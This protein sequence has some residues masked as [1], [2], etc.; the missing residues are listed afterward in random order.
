MEFDVENLEVRQLTLADLSAFILLIHLFNTVFEADQSA[1][2]S[3]ANLLELLSNNHFVAIAAF[4]ENELVGGLTGYELPMY[5]SE[6][7]EIF[8]YD[9]AVKLEYQRRGI[10]IRLIDSLKEYCTK[11]G[12]ND[13]FVLAHTEDMHAIEFYRSTGG[14]SEEVVN[15]LYKA[16][17]DRSD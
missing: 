9:L 16:G 7:S 13:F 8:L 1:V 11:H 10:G 6:N 17:R 3:E 12:N 2:N 4:Y 14:K 15:F 5:Y